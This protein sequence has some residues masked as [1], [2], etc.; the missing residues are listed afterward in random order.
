MHQDQDRRISVSNQDRGLEYYLAVFDHSVTLFT[1]LIKRITNY[2]RT[3]SGRLE[4][5]RRQNR[6]KYG[7]NYNRRLTSALIEALDDSAPWRTAPEPRILP[8]PSISLQCLSL[9]CSLR[10][11][12]A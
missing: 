1:Q 4:M 6:I 3:V 10:R 12:G 8:F 7:I 2:R 5:G 9:V 11:V